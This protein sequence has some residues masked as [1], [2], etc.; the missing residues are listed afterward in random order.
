MVPSLVWTGVPDSEL[1]LMLINQVIIICYIS[2][3][4]ITLLVITIILIIINN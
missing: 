4:I 2:H 3:L 1:N